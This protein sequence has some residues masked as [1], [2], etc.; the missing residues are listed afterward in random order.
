MN[1]LFYCVALLC[2]SGVFMLCQLVLVLVGLQPLQIQAKIQG[3]LDW[4]LLLCV[5]A[6]VAVSLETTRWL[7]G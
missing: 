6:S 3:R 2:A 5:A 4:R 7:V 1:W